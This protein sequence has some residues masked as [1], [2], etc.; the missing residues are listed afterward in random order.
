TSTCRSFTTISS[1]L[2]FF[3][4]IPASSNWLESLLQ[5]GPLFRGQANT[6][7]MMRNRRK[8]TLSDFA[9]AGRATI[10]VQHNLPDMFEP[11]APSDVEL[12]RA[13]VRVM[14]EAGLPVAT[15]GLET[16]AAVRAVGQA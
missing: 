16:F 7:N 15:V 5:G 9:K 13:Y 12:E 8:V 1:G 14:Q 11:A 6:L 10:Q 3:W 2:C 4:G